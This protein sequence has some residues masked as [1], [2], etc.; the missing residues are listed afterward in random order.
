M[1]VFRSLMVPISV[2]R[3]GLVVSMDQTALRVAC[4]A[5]TEGDEVISNSSQPVSDV[6]RLFLPPILV[7]ELLLE[8]LTALTEVHILKTNIWSPA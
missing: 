5:S 8:N 1:L 6:G 7:T 2:A 4:G 3:V